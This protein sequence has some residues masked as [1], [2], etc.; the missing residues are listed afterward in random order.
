VG[1]PILLASTQ[2][3]GHGTVVDPPSRVY[4]VYLSNPENPNFPLAAQAVAIDGTQAYYTWNE[5]SRNIPEAVQQ[6]LPPGFDFSPWLPDAA[7]AS[8]G[9]VDPDSPD[10]PRTYAGLDQVSPDWPTT[11]VQGGTVITVDTYA[12]APHMPSVWDVWMTTADW[13]PTMPLSWDTLEHLGRPTPVLA[14]NHFT[15]DLSIPAD[16]SGHHVLF[17]AWQRDDPVGEVFF[18]TS[19]LDVTPL[20]CI[21]DIDGNGAVDVADLLALLSAWGT[22]GAGANLATPLN[23]VDVA[24]VLLLIDAWGD[25]EG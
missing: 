8:G 19:D 25:C 7:I 18:S 14:N 23:L 4:R 24:D 16:R 2:A 13:N 20:A 9:R 12:T 11:P 6:G 17:V 1:T 3:D 10:Y 15:F 21:G 5:V 22:D